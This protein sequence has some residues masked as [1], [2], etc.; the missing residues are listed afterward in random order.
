MTDPTNTGEASPEYLCAVIAGSL[1]W[2][3]QKAVRQVD[4]GYKVMIPDDDYWKIKH[5]LELLDEM[6]PKA[7]DRPRV[8]GGDD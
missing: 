1:P 5:A 7:D 3:L 4:G 2:L 6:P 8:K